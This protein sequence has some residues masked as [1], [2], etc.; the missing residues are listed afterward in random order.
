[1]VCKVFEAVAEYSAVAVVMACYHPVQAYQGEDGM[2][3]F[4]E[5]RRNRPV[6][7]LELACG[8]CVGCRLERSRQWA[9][10][11]MHEAQM[12]EQNCFITLTYEEKHLPRF[13]SLRYRDFQLFM[14]R[15]RKVAGVHLRFFMCGEYGGQHSRPHFHACIFGYDFLDK[16]F[17]KRGVGGAVIYRSSVLER[18]WPL[19]FSTVGAV[20]FESAAYVAR[21]VLEKA[22]SAAPLERDGL[23]D[24]STGEVV[25]RC[26]EFC[27]MSLKPGIG[28]SWLSK[29]WTDVFPQ[30][31]VVVN[32][33]ERRSPRYYD[34]QFRAV[35]DDGA[36]RLDAD[37]AADA[38]LHFADRSD[39]RLATR[40]FVVQARVNRFKRKV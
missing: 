23:T 8:K 39:S 4:S 40:E 19:G 10:R 33:S 6:R 32:G 34:K 37:R 26:P 38:R 35:D 21:Y 5:L 24:K 36:A 7:T 20:T 31:K 2:V 22:G 14:K 11:C 17:Y 3:A 1:M 15:L 9:V 12:H 25:R 29:F 30:G 28:R 27:H 13:S 18:L 16:V